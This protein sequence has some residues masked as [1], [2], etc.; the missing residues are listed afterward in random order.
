MCALTFDDNSVDVT[1]V[2]GG[3]T[4][5]DK[6]NMVVIYIMMKGSDGYEIYDQLEEL[7]QELVELS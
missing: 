4:S 3:K 2:Q 6:S 7:F 1:S 5:R